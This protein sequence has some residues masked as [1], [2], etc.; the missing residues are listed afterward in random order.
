[1]IPL[2]ILSIIVWAV[3]IERFI[4]YKNWLK[5]N[6]EFLLQFQ[7]LWLKKDLQACKKACESSKTEVSRLA[8]EILKN[9]KEIQALSEKTLAR[10]E[11]L[12]DEQ[13]QLLK[14]NLWILGTIGS[15]TPFVGLFGTVVGIIKAFQS[16]AETGSGGFSVVAAGISEALIATAG[17]IL[18][19]V[20]AVF[21]Y[22]YFLVKV[23]KFQFY[24]GQFTEELIEIFE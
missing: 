5:K 22:N 8:Y 2:F 10:I 18:V 23:S 4:A 13:M 21:F 12:R 17:G 24:L 1:M 19:A 6:Q 14:K 16:I 7:N 15:A 3:A 11:R 9:E 20:I